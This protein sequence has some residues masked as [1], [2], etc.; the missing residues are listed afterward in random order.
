M[1]ATVI[2]AEMDG[3]HEADADE[4]EGSACTCR[5]VRHAISACRRGKVASLS[6]QLRPQ[7][8]FPDR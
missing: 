1:A 3:W 4:R 6:E 2:S 5:K 7:N 8:P